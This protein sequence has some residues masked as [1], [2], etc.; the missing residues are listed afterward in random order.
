MLKSMTAYGRACLV[1]KIGRLT[2]EL[3]CVNRKHLEINTFLPKELLRY[4]AEIKKWIAAAVGRGQVNVK[5]NVVFDRASPLL[6]TPNLPLARQLK[7]AWHAIANDLK[8]QIPDEALVRVL[9]MEDELLVYD[10][11]D[12]D[13]ELYRT[14]LHQ[15]IEQALKQLVSMKITEGRA[16]YE[17]I[18][19]RFAKLAQW[20]QE[21]AAKAPGATNRYREKLAEKLQEVFGSSIEN[22]ERIM[23]ELCVYAEKIDIAEELTRFHSHLKQVNELMGQS[24]TA[25]NQ[26]VGKT[27]EFLVQEL[28][29]EINTIGS[30]SADLDVS[31]LVID[32]KSEL[33]RIR[34]QIQNIE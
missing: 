32:V 3:Q 11:D 28:N 2:V 15:V 18:G 33:E 12:H 5:L 7:N 30:K 17:D 21:I 19:A 24:S 22:E 1:S 31:R 6:I 8:I 27:L 4:D 29:R 14:A 13:E 26:G 20:I 23:R 9:S 16:L 34:E 10:E 25:N